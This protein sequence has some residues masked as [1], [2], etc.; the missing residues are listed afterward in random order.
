MATFVKGDFVQ[1]Q[2][3]V[4]WRW[5]QW[6][7]DHTDFCEKICT[8]TDVKYEQ[9]VN[10]LFIEVDYRG[11]RL[12]FLDHHLIKVDNYEEIYFESIH[13]ACEDLQRHEKIC[14]K[15]RD[16]ILEGVFGDEK[17]IEEEPAPEPDEESIFDDW[18]EVTTKEVIPLPGN[19]GTMTSPHD[20]KATADSNRKKIRRIK[21]L[22]KK[23]SKKDNSST[24]GSL[25]SNWSLTDEELEELQDY[26]DSLPYS[27]PSTTGN[28]DIDYGW[29]EQWD[30][31][32]GN[33][34][35]AD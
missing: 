27:D 21:N 3:T 1:V 20:P 8:V 25:A 17:R 5:D 2:P 7:S 13:K 19:G 30:D 26:I 22:G 12:W 35:S 23:I 15:L 6:S 34:G 14:K 24:S 31:E 18:Q 11:K 9:W 16:E 4:D 10:Q 29:D 28:R 32:W 33:D